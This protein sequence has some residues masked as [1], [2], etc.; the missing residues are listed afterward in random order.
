MRT[1][2]WHLHLW[3]ARYFGP[4]AVTRGVPTKWEDTKR[5]VSPRHA[6]S[7]DSG[8][9]SGRADPRRRPDGGEV[10]SEFPRAPG[11]FSAYRRR[12]SRAW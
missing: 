10:A 2:A 1:S 6:E 7:A 3:P 5:A 9:D 4:R 8:C 11:F 12:P